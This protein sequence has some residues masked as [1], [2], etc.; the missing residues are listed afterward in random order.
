MSANAGLKRVSSGP[1]K[2]D[3]SA[4]AQHTHTTGEHSVAAD[5]TG[6]L[7]LQQLHGNRVVSRLIAAAQAQSQVVQREVEEAEGGEGSLGTPVEIPAESAAV[8]M[9]GQNDDGF[10]DGTVTSNVTPHAFA[11]K[12]KTGKAMIH[13]VGGT[14]GL[15]NQNVGSIDVTAPVIE[16]ADPT[17][18]QTEGRAWVK[19]GTGKAKATRSYTG[20]PWG[21]NGPT[22]YLTLA[23]SFRVDKHEKLHVKATKAAHDTH[24]KPLEK[25]VSKNRGKSSALKSGATGVEAAATLTTALDWNAA[26]A[27]FANEDTTEN[28]PMGNVDNA[29]LASGTYIQ[30]KGAKKVRGTDY[31]HYY[32][33]P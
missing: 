14:G 25:R 2:S 9:P 28:T 29:D 24:I 26:I 10:Y 17:G 23:G 30:D 3:A 31:A 8:E 4:R 5:P 20:A 13:W 6:L 18:K 27:A 22:A 33:T 16:S 12:G 21:A 32:D 19:S 7:A 15:G 1:E 11:D